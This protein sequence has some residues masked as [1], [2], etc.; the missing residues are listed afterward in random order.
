MKTRVAPKLPDYHA[1]DSFRDNLPIL[2]IFTPRQTLCMK[3]ARSAESDGGRRFK[4]LFHRGSQGSSSHGHP[5]RPGRLDGRRPAGRL[6]V[7]WSGRW[8][9]CWLV[10]EVAAPRPA[11]A[12]SPRLVLWSSCRRV[13]DIGHAGPILAGFPGIGLGSGVDASVDNCCPARC[14]TGRACVNGS[15]KSPLFPVV[16]PGGL[17]PLLWTL[18]QLVGVQIPIPQLDLR[19][20]ANL[21]CS[22]CAA[23]WRSFFASI[24][25]VAAPCLLGRFGLSGRGRIGFQLLV[26]GDVTDIFGPQRTAEDFMFAV[27]ECHS[28][29]RRLRGRRVG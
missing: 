9:P 10:A 4:T 3:A 2:T 26:L 20:F 6:A 27:A 22:I 18:D 8:S 16:L 5:C 25:R 24:P 19:Q 14:F 13:V 11:A 29:R 17:A 23:G 21:L 1:R 15:R 28:R 7:S 12:V